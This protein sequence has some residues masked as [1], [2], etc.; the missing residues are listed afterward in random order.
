V[1]KAPEGALNPWSE[2]EAIM[3]QKKNKK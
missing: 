2:T 3:S 1:E